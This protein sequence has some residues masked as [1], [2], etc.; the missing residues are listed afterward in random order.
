MTKPATTKREAQKRKLDKAIISA[1]EHV[2]MK[3]GFRAATMDEIAEQASVTK[4]TLYKHFPS[5]LA[6]FVGMTDVYLSE[7]RNVLTEVAD[8]DASPDTR[9]K[10]LYQAVFRFTMQHQRFMRLFWIVDS[11]EFEGEMPKDLVERVQGPTNEG[12]TKYAEAMAEASTQGVIRPFDPLLLVHLL[13]AVNKGI[14]MHANKERQYE[15]A[16][17]KPE[18]LFEL[19]M[20]ILDGGLFVT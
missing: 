4:R 15:I 13:S 18:E 8:Q 14:F 12:F 3:K 1:A 20:S 19:F 5:K 2:F 6:L 7:L 17:I 9:I 11:E 16:D 10:N